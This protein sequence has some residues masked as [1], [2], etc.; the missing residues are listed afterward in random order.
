MLAPSQK[1][2]DVVKAHLRVFRIEL[3]AAA[4]SSVVLSLSRVDEKCSP[5]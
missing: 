3:S 1:K 5:W 2:H 4:S